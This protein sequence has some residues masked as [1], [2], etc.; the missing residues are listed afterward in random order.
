MF[1]RNTGWLSLA[2]PGLRS[3][4][5]VAVVPPRMLVARLK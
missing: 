4:V 1:A 2:L 3:A 5:D